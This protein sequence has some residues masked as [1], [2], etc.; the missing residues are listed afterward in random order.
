M[1]VAWRAKDVEARIFVL[2]FYGVCCVCEQH[3]SES[4]F[5]LDLTGTVCLLRFDGTGF[6]ILF[7]VIA[8]MYICTGI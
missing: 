5:F 6:L 4:S 2:F 1:V 8:R 3:V 7:Y